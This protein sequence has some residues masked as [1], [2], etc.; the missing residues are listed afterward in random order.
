MWYLCARVKQLKTIKT[1]K[2][3][4]T[5]AK[6]RIITRIK[7]MLNKP[8]GD[9]FNMLLLAYNRW[10]EDEH[11]GVDYI[12]NINNPDDLIDCIKGGLTADE[13]GNF[14]RVYVTPN[15]LFGCNHK[16][17]PLSKTKIIKL[18]IDNLDD[19]VDCI[20]AY[21]WVEEYRVIY[22]EVVTNRLLGE[23]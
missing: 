20:I 18:I 19:I 2:S 5:I 17:T 12:F 10:Q 4:E 14:V 9:Y 11:S 1:M 22:V 16:L 3:F 23:Y 7:F 8:S 15:F 13:I 6:A 21:P